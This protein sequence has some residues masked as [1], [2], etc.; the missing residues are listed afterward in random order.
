MWKEYYITTPV[1]NPFYPKPSTTS[2][3][4]IGKRRTSEVVMRKNEGRRQLEDG[5]PSSI[6]QEVIFPR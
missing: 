4:F 5:S 6:F 1:A 3:F 2:A